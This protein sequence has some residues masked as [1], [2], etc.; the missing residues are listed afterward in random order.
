MTA[1][2]FAFPPY[3]E[4]VRNL[5]KKDLP[6]HRAILMH[7][8]IGVAGEGGELKKAHN[9]ANTIEELG[10]IEFYIQAACNDVADHGA[11]LAVIAVTSLEPLTAYNWMDVV[12]TAG[13]DFLDAV[14][15]SWVYG[16]RE[17]N[18]AAVAQAIFTLQSALAFGYEI[19]G[20]TR[21]EVRY[22]NQVKLIGKD[23][24]YKSGVYSDAAALARADKTVEAPTAAG[25]GVGTLIAGSIEASA[26]TKGE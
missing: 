11:N 21:E 25:S 13:S 3:E 10:D 20:T 17:P 5:F 9:R 1:K 2:E 6:G 26:L 14:K 4:M 19:L 23:G 15:K 16:D 7:S 24:R 18:L 22:L 12:H 8:A